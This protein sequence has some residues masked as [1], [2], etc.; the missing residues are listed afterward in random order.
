MTEQEKAQRT[1]RQPPKPLPSVVELLTAIGQG[2]TKSGPLGP[3]YD[4]ATRAA[5]NGVLSMI[6]QQIANKELEAKAKANA[7]NQL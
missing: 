7:A 6:N 5:L 2:F 3:G 4:G 1:G